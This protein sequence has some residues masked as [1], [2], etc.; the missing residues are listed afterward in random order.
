[1]GRTE[2][3]TKPILWGLPEPLCATNAPLG[4]VYITQPCQEPPGKGG[5]AR[6]RNCCRSRY[7][8]A[9]C[10]DEIEVNLEPSYVVQVNG[11]YGYA[12][13]FAGV[14][15]DTRLVR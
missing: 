3:A 14:P 11:F 1:M 12:V 6:C 10:P 4:S 5:P 13:N 2:I 9:T 8:M 7:R 15:K